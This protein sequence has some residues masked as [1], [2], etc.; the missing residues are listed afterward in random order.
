M[1]LAYCLEGIQ[2]S[3]IRI[4]DTP[5][6]VPILVAALFLKPQRVFWKWYIFK[7]KIHLNFRA[8]N[9]GISI[10]YARCALLKIEKLDIL[11]TF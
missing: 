4:C 11:V 5:K 6:Q 8:K 7:R 10:L 3:L 2:K 1:C 9:L